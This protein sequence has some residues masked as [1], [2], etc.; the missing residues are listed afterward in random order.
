[1][2][3]NNKVAVQAT[4]PVPEDLVGR[5]DIWNSLCDWAKTHKPSCQYL[6][7]PAGTGKTF[8]MRHVFHQLSQG[9]DEAVF[10][11]S[12]D[13][14]GQ[15]PSTWIQHVNRLMGLS[16]EPISS[17]DQLSDLLMVRCSL[18]PF[19]WVIDD[20][21]Q[22]KINRDWVVATALEL[23]TR[24]A[25]VILVGRSS[26]LQLWP[27]QSYTRGQIH[28]IEIGDLDQSAAHALLMSSGVT[29][30][31]IVNRAIEISHGRPQ[32][33]SAIS[34]GLSLLEETAVPAGQW[35]FMANPVDTAGYLI[36]QICHPGSRR[37]MWRAGHPTDRIDTMIAVASLA[38]MFN[39]DWLA[40]VAGRTLVNELWDEFVALPFLHP[41]RGGYYGV[42][43]HLREEI[44]QT[45]QKVRP[46]MW[47]HWTR[48]AAAHYLGRIQAG[49]T[50]REHA[51]NLL[52]RFV[53]PHLGEAIFNVDVGRLVLHH[54]APSDSQDGFVHLA[55]RT[56]M[57]VASARLTA[58][59]TGRLMVDT[60]RWDANNPATLLQLVSS[61]A[62]QF[63]L[64]NEVEW[65]T[66][67]TEPALDSLL[68]ILK[69]DQISENRWR[70]TLG[71]SEY[72]K[73]LE[74]M[75]AA[76]MGQ[77]PTDPVGLVQSVLLSLK[78]GMDEYNPEAMEYWNSVCTDASSFRT[79]F[80]DALNSADLG[81]QIDGKTVLV[82]YYLDRRGTHEKL[83]E[84]LHV[85][86]ATYFRNHR[87]ALERL[88]QAVFE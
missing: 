32:L 78:D 40:R 51:W 2:I 49:S 4:R 25:S 14:Q 56:G 22:L 12:G 13:S 57:D 9:D 71:P 38:P 69:F 80:L 74:H 26:P 65:A 18:G 66:N 28:M 35:A 81:D 68:A 39:R 16:I 50:P 52:S 10:W 58:A 63:H 44:A 24:G 84:I 76:P 54:Q 34:D 23:S 67:G 17:M 8:L 46:W 29:D 37:L 88:A 72:L 85:S 73:W 82:L 31:L 30:P 61:V 20:F 64:Y 41:Y 47:E 36:E 55:D 75:V 87:V 42:F 19:M 15:S 62:N 7:G 86:R 6:W 27:T 53:R 70:L 45:V 5:D 79:W 43:P 83:A 11:T 1:M 33:L 3:A 48:S 21:D 77:R 60:A 59:T